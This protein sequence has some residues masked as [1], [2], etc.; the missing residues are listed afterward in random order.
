MIALILATLSRT[1][2]E[3]SVVSCLESAGI[4]VDLA[5]DMGTF[6]KIFFDFSGLLHVATYGLVMPGQGQ[7]LRLDSATTWGT[8]I[9]S[10]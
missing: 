7:V 2:D 5:P 10:L 6:S 8:H 9:T 4:W 3:S 1:T